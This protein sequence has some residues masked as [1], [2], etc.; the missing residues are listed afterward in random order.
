MKDMLT[1]FVSSITASG[2]E[3]ASVGVKG[4]T[5]K[6]SRTGPLLVRLF[7]WH[8][9]SDDVKQLHVSHPI[10]TTGLE[11]IEVIGR[12]LTLPLT[13][14]KDLEAAIPFQAEPLLP[15]PTEQA[16]L[17]Y[18]V[19]TQTAK[20]TTITVLATP[21]ETLQSHLNE[22]KAW[23]IEPEQISCIPFALCQFGSVYFPAVNTCL[24]LHVQQERLTAVLMQRGKLLSTFSLKEGLEPLLKAL[25]TEGMAFPQHLDEWK[26][27][28]ESPHSQSIAALTHLQRSLAKMSYALTK[29]F[30]ADP[31]EGVIITGE[32][33]DYA[34]LPEMLIQQSPFPLL[35]REG[36]LS[37]SDSK[38]E[39]YAVPIGLALGSLPGQKG[40]DFRQREFSYPYPWARLKIPLLTTFFG[41]LGISLAFYFLSHHYLTYQQ[42]LLKQNYVNLLAG[43]DKSH[44]QFETAFIAK[45]P[46]SKE[47]FGDRIPSLHE[48]NPDDLTQ[49]LAFLQK[50]LQSTPD[51]FPLFPH[52][53]RVS[54]VLAWLAQH[55]AVTSV[56]EEGKM[57]THVQIENFSYTMIK[58][59]QHGKKQEKYQVK[60]ELELVSS[61]PKWARKFHDALIVP[62]DWVDPKGEI[63]WSAN[64]D[65]YKTS[66]FLKDKTLYPSS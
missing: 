45:H 57:Q 5:L 8:P 41:L 56:D 21:K 28:K 33:A 58:R 66:F 47:H 19:V 27:L 44:D 49:R 23:L 37:Y 63:K 39:S 62:N 11:G 34:G 55:P 40:I 10:L 18:Q 3:P 17:T 29:D 48:L 20:E 46:Q 51:S 25:Q 22:W 61:T 32:A 36:D 6:T 38:L 54:D 59:P 43:I 12:S 42:D 31:I 1:T 53:P 50:E 24:L 64:R 52:L 15:Y 13:K 35:K 2:L 26:I 9:D 16:L 30:K 65:K 14:E 60:I 7:L 4:A